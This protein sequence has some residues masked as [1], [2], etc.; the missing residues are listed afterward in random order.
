[1][2][3]AP[4]HASNK[5]AAKRMP[6]E[7]LKA[8]ILMTETGFPVDITIAQDAYGDACRPAP[9]PGWFWVP[10]TP[11]AAY[12]IRRRGLKAIGTLTTTFI[13]RQEPVVL[14]HTHRAG[15]VPAIGTQAH[16]ELMLAETRARGE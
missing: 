2:R 13:P 7:F 15:D 1:M 9:E 12:D 14:D 5:E 11:Q 16:T 6:V 8:K 4:V 10:A 3:P